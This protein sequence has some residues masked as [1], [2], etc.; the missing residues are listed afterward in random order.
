MRERKVHFT[1]KPTCGHGQGKY[2]NDYRDVT[3]ENCKRTKAYQEAVAEAESKR[4]PTKEEFNE[5]Y[6]VFEWETKKGGLLNTECKYKKGWEEDSPIVAKLGSGYCKDC[7]H[8]KGTDKKAQT[9]KC[10]YLHDTQK[11]EKEMHDTNEEKIIGSEKYLTT[12]YDKENNSIQLDVY[13]IVDCNHFPNE[14]AVHSFK[15]LLRA[16]KGHK[17]LLEDYK[18]A[19]TQLGMSIKRIEMKEERK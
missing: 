14:E 6:E 9:I 3:C 2:T 12:Y 13:D 7:K 17:S 10:S 1:I 15:K 16:G 11:I 4:K 18:E 19:Y 5:P 8:N